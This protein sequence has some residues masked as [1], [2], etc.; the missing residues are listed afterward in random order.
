MD[1]ALVSAICDTAWGYLETGNEVFDLDGCTFVRNRA[2][3][4]RWDANQVTRIRCRASTD[5]DLLFENVERE[6][7]GCD[8]RRFAVD[9]LTPPSVVA[10]LVLQDYPFVETVWLGLDGELAGGAPEVDIRLMQTEQDWR[11]TVPL[12]EAEWGEALRKQRRAVD[13]SIVPEFVATKR[14]KSPPIRHWMAY[15][16]GT[17]CA[18]FSSWEGRNGI[19]IIEDLFTLP[20]YR[21]RGIATAL[22]HHCVADARAHGASM[23]IIGALSDDTP[24]RMYAAMGFRPLLTTRHYTRS[25]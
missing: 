18:Y 6:Y 20:R 10:R 24:K 8:H 23:I 5:I 3:P 25:F 11:N 17:A 13:N 1:E 4:R 2:C 21:H 14:A 7:D 9:P 15:V 19:G 12:V 16:G 22:L